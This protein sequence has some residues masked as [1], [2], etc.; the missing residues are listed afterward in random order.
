MKKNNCNCK[1]FNVDQAKCTS[2]VPD[3]TYYYHIFIPHRALLAQRWT[4]IDNITGPFGPFYET[5]PYTDPEHVYDTG[6]EQ[7]FYKSVLHH[8]FKSV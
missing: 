6:S 8:L 1:L 4:L 7:T 3:Y 2:L 5:D